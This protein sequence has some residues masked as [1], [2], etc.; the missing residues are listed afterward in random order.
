M[1][2]A[3]FRTFC[4]ISWIHIANSRA[5]KQRN[6]KLRLTRK[7]GKNLRRIKPWTDFA[8]FT[9]DILDQYGGSSKSREFS[10]LYDRNMCLHNMCTMSKQVCKIMKLFIEGQESFDSEIDILVLFAVVHTLVWP[11]SCM[12]LYFWLL[13]WL[14]ASC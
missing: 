1:K 8:K 13:W 3:L 14:H 12:L 9:K 10:L 7:K 2:V 5:G 6:K 11:S 4:L